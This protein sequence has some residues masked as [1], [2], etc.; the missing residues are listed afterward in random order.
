MELRDFIVTPFVILVVCVLAYAIR[1]LV[2]DSVNRKFFIPALIVR[3]IG[4]LMFGFVYQ[5]YYKGGDTFMYHKYGS[6]I[7]WKALLESPLT[8]IKLLLTSGGENISG[9]YDYTSKIFFYNDIQSYT[10]VRIAAAFDFMTYSTYSATSVLFAVVSF[11][12]A[13]LLF[14]TFYKQYPEKSFSIALATL[15]VPSVFFWG[16]GIMKDTL[17]LSALGILTYSVN[18]LFIKRD[19]SLLLIIFSVFSIYLIFLIKIY[20]LLVFLPALITWVFI[21]NFSKI[22]IKVAKVILAPMV[23]FTIVFLAYVAVE[24]ISEDN[25]RY[26]LDK[27]AVTARTTAYDIRY[28]TGRD[29]G[30]GY[31]LGELDGTFTSLASLAP[32]AI[33]VTLFRPYL[34]E[35]KNPL[36]LFSSLESTTCLLLFLYIII[37]RKHL[38]FMALSNPDILF[39]CIVTLVFSFAVG[40][41]TYN[42]G[43]LVRYKIP[44]IPFFLLG[45]IL[46]ESYS[47]SARKFRALDSSE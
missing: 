10:V 3:I 29:A 8:G 26:S 14:L 47:K 41:S 9:A 6:R 46:L 35:I 33:N 23:M 27:I 7:I 42:F 5:F 11:V 20:I 37:R 13:W 12:G 31:S 24:K 4:S 44:M 17:T 30:S 34:W 39:L 45:L 25:A 16:S 1:P 2:T 18:R 21:S 38:V 28:W 40:I 36:M 22:K 43:S 15:F 32:Q 19:Y